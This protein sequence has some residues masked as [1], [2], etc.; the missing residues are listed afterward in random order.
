MQ[1]LNYYTLD[2]FT[3]QMFGGNQ[4]AVFPDAPA[5]DD[6]LMQSIANEFNYPETVFVRP[7]ASDTALRRLRIFTPA[8]ELPFAG[9]PTIG[10][11]QLLVELDLV[12]AGEDNV[13]A[14]SLEEGIG[15]VP[16]TVSGNCDG[17][18]FTWLTAPR[19]PERIAGSPSKQELAAVIG[20]Q[21]E[22]I[23]INGTLEPG[24]YSAG[25]PFTFIPVRDRESLRR[26]NIDL[27]H[28][29][30]VLA[31]SQAPQ[32]YAFCSGD[33]DGDVDFHARMFAPGLGIPED[34]A[35]GG[36]VA[37]FA[38][39]IAEAAGQD[40]R[41]IIAQ[42]EDMGRPGRI[43]LATE[44]DGNRLWKVRVGGSAIRVSHGILTVY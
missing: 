9:H 35:T 13:W 41:W 12:A 29:R 2:V 1:E 4:L 32:I 40:G 18:Y 37:A 38:G 42:G 19:L 8:A 44:S 26:I 23:G 11:A 43:A 30:N 7:A 31:N 20:L 14:F 21:P 25:V 28:W 5:L 39:Y 6:A 16:V 34:P 27:E 24:L 10:T 17:R 36:A 33:E 15:P 3:E 22:A